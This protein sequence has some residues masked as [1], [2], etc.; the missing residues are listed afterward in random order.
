[1]PVGDW[2]RERRSSASSRQSHRPSRED[3]SRAAR[4]A[5]RSGLAL[6]A[7][8]EG[9]H[10]ALTPRR[11]SRSTSPAAAGEVEDERRLQ[12]RMRRTTLTL[13]LFPPPQ[14]NRSPPSDSSP[15]TPAPG[16]MSSVS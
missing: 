2:L 15:E 9:G 4:S 6:D 11:Q 14:K 3:G 1:M 12:R 10:L 7:P 16:G 5:P 13:P 8:A